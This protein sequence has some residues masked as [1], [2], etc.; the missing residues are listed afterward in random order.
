MGAGCSILRGWAWFSLGQHLQGE[1]RAGLT[2]CGEIWG[3]GLGTDWRGRCLRA[4]LCTVPPTAIYTGAP[5][6]F[7]LEMSPPILSP[8]PAFPHP[9]FPSVFPV[10]GLALCPGSGGG[11]DEGSSASF[12]L[13]QDVGRVGG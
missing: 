4:W 7:L 6:C 12:L 11:C 1:T 9:S 5:A 3:R 13:P 10:A 2:S 8:L